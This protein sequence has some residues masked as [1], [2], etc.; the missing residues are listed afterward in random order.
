MSGKHSSTRTPATS[1]DNMGWEGMGGHGK[2]IDVGPNGD[3]Y[4]VTA[5]GTHKTASNS[6]F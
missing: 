3:A 6:V 4:V 5:D 2:R 1:R